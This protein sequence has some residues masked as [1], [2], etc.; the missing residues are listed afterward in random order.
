[1]NERARDG[2]GESEAG[3]TLLEAIVSLAV[4]TVVLIGLLTL[5]QVNSRVAKAQVNVAE[6]QQSLRVVQSDM[7]RMTRMAGRGG[8]P[9][10]RLGMPLP[11]GPS[12]E[13]LSGA[14]PGTNIA[15][16]G[17]AAVVEGT[18]ILTVR[19]VISTPLY[20]LDPTDDGDVRNAKAAREGSI[21]VRRISPSGVPQ[22]LKWLKE[23]EEDFRPEALLLVSAGSDAIQAVVELKNVVDNGDDS[24]T[25][26]FWVADGQH[27]TD[28]EALS[29]G[30]QFPD[31]LR[32]V[33]MAGI[34]E[35][36]KY[37]VR[38]E[39]P[40]PRL[41]RARLYPGTDTA[42][43]NDDNNLHADIADNI[44]D[45]QVALGID[46][47]GD[48]LLPDDG[49]VDD[50]WLFNNEKDDPD[51]V[52]WNPDKPLYYLRISTLARTDR[53]DPEYTS[54]PIQKIED[55]DYGEV[56]APAMGE[57]YERKYRRRLLQTVV[58]LRN[59]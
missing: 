35:E 40:V 45:L 4:M 19:G 52:N 31:N 49:T 59:L 58:G 2:H 38:D 26:D 37:Y 24:F 51:D 54:P 1:M 6:M 18:D 43:A 29:P 12:I 55:H 53:L 42:Y 20:Q 17:A 56:D 3:F 15:E 34:V 50:D 46:K 32:T 27:S 33:A 22:E 41:S 28:Y 13:V 10:S 57:E 14:D 25:V 39:P 11:V 21:T 47:N 9:S 30:G 7:V 16:N 36:Y 23:L 5:L 44:L 8:L 48:G